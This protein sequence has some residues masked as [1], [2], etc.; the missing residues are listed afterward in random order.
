MKNIQI[1][2]IDS[3]L[4]LPK[5]ETGGSVGFDLYTRVNFLMQPLEIV[6]IPS[7]IIMKIPLDTM[8]QIS[9]RSSAPKKFGIIMPHGVGVIDQDYCGNEDE[10]M[11]Q[12]QNIL[13]GEAYIPRG[14]KIAQGVL[15]KIE[16]DFLWEEIEDMEDL[17][18]GGFG[19]TD[20]K[21]TQNK[22]LKDRE[23]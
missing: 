8:L 22:L 9:L 14:T 6:L 11:I 2:R 4:P 10:I 16:R 18:R 3:S 21:N 7:N 20:L 5:F 23:R 15:V 17:S 13:P 1:K 19:S 12:V